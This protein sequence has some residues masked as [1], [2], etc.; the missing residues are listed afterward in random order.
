MASME[1]GP[2]VAKWP[3]L[4]TYFIRANLGR[5]TIRGR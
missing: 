3:V 2:G 4:A 5:P 1:L